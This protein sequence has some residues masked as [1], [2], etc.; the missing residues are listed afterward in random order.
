MVPQ[1]AFAAM[2]EVPKVDARLKSRIFPSWNRLFSNPLGIPIKRILLTCG[3]SIRIV[4][5]PLK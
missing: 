1:T 4:R 3:K 5:R 2:A